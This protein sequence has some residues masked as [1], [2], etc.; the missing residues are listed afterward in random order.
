MLNAR[1]LA[2]WFSVA[3]IAAAG[4]GCARLRTS[5]DTDGGVDAASDMREVAGDRSVVDAVPDTATCGAGTKACAGTCVPTTD[6]ATGCAGTSCA[7]CMVANASAA[8]VMGACAVGTCAADYQDC[9]GIAANGC[10][11]NTQTSGSDCGACHHACTGGQACAAGACACPAGQTLCSG[12]CNETGAPCTAGMGA[13][14]RSGSIVCSGTTTAC[15]AVAGAP[16]AETCNGV[17]DDCDG[18]VD[19]IPSMACTA[20]VGGCQRSGTMACSGTMA[21]CNAVAGSPVTE[22]CNAVDDDCNGMVDDIASAACMPATECRVGMSACVAGGLVCNATGNASA[23]AACTSITGG[24]CGGTGACA[25]PAG[26]SNCGGFCRATGAACTT[27]VGACQRSGTVTCSGTTTACSAVAGAPTT[28]T[29]NNVDDNCDATVDNITSTVCTSP[30][31]CRTGATA[32]AAGALVCNAAG[33]TLAGTVC[34]SIA[35]GVCN[36]AGACACAAG[37][38]N[39]SG[40]CRTTQTDNA[41]CGTCGNA[42]GASQTCMTGTCRCP[43][44]SFVSGLNCVPQ[45][46]CPDPIERGCGLVEVT[47]GT[48]AMGDTAGLFS[49][50]VQT[51]ITVGNFAMDTSEVTVAR[52]RRYWTAGHP[53]APGSTIT[54]PGG[55]LSW[56]G[57]VS[58]P[59]T[60][61][62]CNWST[63]AGALEAHPI[64]CA[65]WYT[66]QGFCVWDGGRLPT[67]A[68]WEYAAR[69]RS[70][71]GL[72]VPRIYP[73]GNADP[74]G[75]AQARWT[76]TGCM[77]D[78]G[79][80]TR[81]VNGSAATGGL[82][83]LAGNVLEW[84]ADWHAWYDSTTCW[85]GIARTNP[86]CND[87]SGGYKA[88]HGGAWDH[89]DVAYL[90]SATR[91]VGVPWSNGGA[92]FRCA[93]TR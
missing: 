68:E 75:C 80:A 78:D 60:T 6:T 36:G 9:D 29:C 4:V 54:Y 51:S 11:A 15:S 12:V 91:F 43:A 49:T 56:S 85:G 13:C 77:G 61:A 90:R 82:Y 35:G 7:P 40:T 16:V 20:G 59:G 34:T 14:A 8:C 25:C 86:I 2:A 50:P 87:G 48:F 72:P 23:G 65:D 74:T 10:E 76:T 79:A 3:A 53:D 81:R 1:T 47:G 88:L 38:T 33:N 45:R 37:Q 39:C 42:C 55:T 26:Q 70:V 92:G 32:C 28:E 41:N 84:T 66:A 57:G 58:E 19:N 69:G 27:G 93:R 63:V 73:W 21:A 18:T 24:V 5:H 52:F 67:E 89:A 22:T 30:V 83:D 62:Q 71:S 17:D 64:N 44:G 46:S 31:E